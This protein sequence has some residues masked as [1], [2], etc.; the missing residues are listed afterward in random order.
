VPTLLGVCVLVDLGGISQNEVISGGAS[1]GTGRAL[2]A[3]GTRGRG[4][5]RNHMGLSRIWYLRRGFGKHRAGSE[6]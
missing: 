4:D 3:E 5:L 6:F 2:N 1:V